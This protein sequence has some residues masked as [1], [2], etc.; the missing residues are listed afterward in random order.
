MKYNKLEDKAI[1]ILRDHITDDHIR[2]R[3]GK[4]VNLMNSHRAALQGP[5][6]P[7]TIS[8]VRNRHQR[9]TKSEHKRKRNKCGTCGRL[10]RGHTC[11]L[12]GFFG[13]EDAGNVVY[14]L[15]GIE[16]PTEQFE[17]VEDML[18]MLTLPND[19]CDQ[20]MP[21]NTPEYMDGHELHALF[22]LFRS[23]DES[24]EPIEK[25]QVLWDS[26]ERE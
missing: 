19:A 10:L 9:M 23:Y 7:Y 5:N 26:M 18:D 22:E 1:E 3:W 17:I 25:Y 6:H 15:L 4:I 16:K 12:G 8:M 20:S 2:P 14:N 13:E 24:P 21:S 11:I